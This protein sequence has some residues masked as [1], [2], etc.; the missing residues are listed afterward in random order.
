M[1]WLIN[2]LKRLMNIQ[3]TNKTT[4]STAAK[5]F[6]VVY[7]SANNLPDINIGDNIRFL[8]FPTV[9]ND[10]ATAISGSDYLNMYKFST[11][12]VY[13]SYVKRVVSGKQ[14]IN[15]SKTKN[16]FSWTY[17]GVDMINI[18]SPYF[19][20]TSDGTTSAEFFYILFSQEITL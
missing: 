16:I 17:Q 3:T 20:N 18:F 7:K 14:V 13:T 10:N 5:Q 1:K 11:P 2:L 6:K 12:L 15:K 8:H 9:V 19:F 4:D